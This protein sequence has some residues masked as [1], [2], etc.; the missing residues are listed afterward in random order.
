MYVIY[1]DR[2]SNPKAELYMIGI[3]LDRLLVFQFRAKSHILTA[4]ESS[5]IKI[6]PHYFKR[7]LIFWRHF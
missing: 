2:Y 6:I 4:L 5:L 1:F 3:Y 7:L